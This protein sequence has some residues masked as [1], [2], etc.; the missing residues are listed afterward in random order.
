MNKLFKR[1][2]AI[3]LSTMIAF[4][5]ISCGNNAEKKD[6]TANQSSQVGEVVYPVT[7]TDSFGKEVTLDK[8][9][10]KIIS[11]APNITEMIYELGAEGKLVGRTDYC[12]Y[13]KE[14]TNIESIGSLM[15][16][17]IEKIISLE[18]DLVITSTHFDKEN[19]AKLEAAGIKIIGL[20]EEHDVEATKDVAEM[21]STIKE[22]TDAVK[23]LEEPTVYYVVGYGEYGDFSAPENTF[24]GEIIKLAGGDNIVPA[25]DN[26]SYSLEALLEADPEII[27]IGN[28]MK[29]G[30]ETAEGYKELTAV[31]EG[32]VYEIDNNLIDR[33]GY[34]N[35]EGVMTLA[36]IF[37]PEAFQQ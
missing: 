20:Y 21:K 8:E 9:P 30:F 37:H 12:D 34:R 32:K 5:L 28:G 35:A 33:Q 22:V 29:D 11:V 23:D 7:I 13:P 19:T 14:V 3:S 26:W 10:K 36:K 31:K 2:A 1:F 18:P 16:P 4:G 6:N 24:A 17:D 27:I 25:Q 15:T